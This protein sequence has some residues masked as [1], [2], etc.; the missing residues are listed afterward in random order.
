MVL[1]AVFEG[2]PLIAAKVSP[3]PAKVGVAHVME[4]SPVTA[5]TTTTSPVCTVIEAVT[6]AVEGLLTVKG[7]GEA[8]IS[9]G[10]AIT[11]FSVALVADHAL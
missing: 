1:L 3:V 11:S 9:V 2:D 6:R 4:L 8:E 10:C 7:L 5:V